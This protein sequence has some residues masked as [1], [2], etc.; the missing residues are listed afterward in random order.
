MNASKTW[1]YGKPCLHSLASHAC[2]PGSLR[3][4]RGA[5]LRAESRALLHLGAAVGAMRL[6][7]LLW[8]QRITALHTKF[9]A[10]LIG[11]LAIGAD[12]RGRSIC[13]PAT[14]ERKRRHI[15]ELRYPLVALRV[16]AGRLL[17]DKHV[18][19]VHNLVA[20]AGLHQGASAR[21]N[22]QRPE[23]REE[24]A[25]RADGGLINPA[26]LANGGL[27]SFGGA[28]HHDGDC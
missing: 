2:R 26:L 25:D 24:K 14:S 10:W 23:W 20:Q 13:R 21:R 12:D 28:L 16:R 27:Q 7:F 11:C 6:L 18:Q 17:V 5:A 3:R 22:H 19:P 15:K 8:C 4:C 9:V 1:K